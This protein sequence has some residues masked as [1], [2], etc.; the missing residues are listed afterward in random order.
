[1]SNINSFT[2]SQSDWLKISFLAIHFIL[3]K[4]LKQLLGLETIS[5]KISLEQEVKDLKSKVFSNWKTVSKGLENVCSYT[6]K[7]SRAENSVKQHCHVIR[8]SRCDKY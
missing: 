1:M 6:P 5:N 3:L 8:G 4:W 2:L 7:S